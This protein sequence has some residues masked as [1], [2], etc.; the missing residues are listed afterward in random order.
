MTIVTNQTVRVIVNSPPDYN[1]TNEPLAGAAISVEARALAQR[2]NEVGA[3]GGNIQF[4]VKG[5]NF[6][7][8]DLRCI[9][10]RG[11]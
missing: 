5:N 1:Y 3:K 7:E 9:V 8:L 6:N 4:S 11:R 2:L 10:S